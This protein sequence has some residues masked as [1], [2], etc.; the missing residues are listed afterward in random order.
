VE[1]QASPKVS[2]SA[3]TIKGNK[4][5]NKAKSSKKKKSSNGDKAATAAAVPAWV[6]ADTSDEVEM[7]DQQRIEQEK[8]LTPFMRRG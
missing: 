8:V 7:T 5:E 2:V 3:I 4:S 1:L 6:N